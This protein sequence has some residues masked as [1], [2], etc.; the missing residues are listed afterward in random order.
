MT[1]IAEPRAELEGAARGALDQAR[2]IELLGDFDGSGY[3]DGASLVRRPDGQMVQLGPLLYAL[4]ECVDGR[5]DVVA[6]SPDA[7]RS[8]SAAG[9]T[10]STSP[11]SPKS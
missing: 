3:E 8:M 7:S 1:T 11:G 2:G 9:S 5:R 6:S 4:L 10:R